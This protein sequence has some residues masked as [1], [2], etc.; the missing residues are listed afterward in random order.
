MRRRRFIERQRAAD[1]VL[2]MIIT[3]AATV[4]VNRIFLQLT[5]F[6]QIGNSELH[7]AH[8]LWGGLIV[9]VGATLPL[10]YGN[11]WVYR[12]SAILTGIGLGLFFDEVGKFLTQDN[13]Y[14]FRPAASIIYILFLIGIY[15]AA[16]VRRGEPDAQT[17]LHHALELMQEIVDGNFEM[18][19]KIELEA[20]LESITHDSQADDVSELATALLKFVREQAEV[21]PDQPRRLQASWR[22]AQ[23]WLQEHILT[24]SRTRWLLMIST[25]FLAISSLLDLVS[26]IT[27][28]GQANEIDALFEGWVARFSLTG[29]QVDSSLIAMIVLKGVVGLLLLGALALFA[30][31]LDRYGITLALSGLLLSITLFNVLL[32]YYVQFVAAIPVIIDLV[33]IAGLKFYSQRHLRSTTHVL[34][35]QLLF[36]E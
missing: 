13:D 33:L 29:G 35:R 27:S 9:A 20:M 2:T 10:I 5:G 16:T 15:V 28:I 34:P 1:Y 36:A 4:L 6:P 30:I 23:T 8:V 18:H 22:Q 7:I 25:G 24:R 12:I 17:R 21:I 3:F 26:L 19:E 11:R 32:F 31:G 14:F